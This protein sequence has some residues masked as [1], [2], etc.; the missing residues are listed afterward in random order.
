[1]Y[2]PAIITTEQASHPLASGDDRKGSLILVEIT[3]CSNI[4]QIGFTVTSEDYSLLLDSTPS[5][6]ASYNPTIF[7][8]KPNNQVGS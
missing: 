7:W 4:G 3:P 5:A 1:M 6:Q 8:S 2:S